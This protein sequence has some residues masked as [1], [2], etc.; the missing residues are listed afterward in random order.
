MGKKR[1]L[2]PF[3]LAKVKQYKAEGR[4]V[5]WIMMRFELSYEE[6]QDVIRDRQIRS[7]HRK[8][9]QDIKKPAINEKKSEHIEA[10]RKAL[11]NAQLKQLQKEY[12][13]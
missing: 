3:E 9:V 5:K 4:S 8:V 1:R 2:L 10:L 13:G 12:C 7:R 6:F 11:E